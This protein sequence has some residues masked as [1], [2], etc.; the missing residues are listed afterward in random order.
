MTNDKKKII[1]R[2]AFTLYSIIISFGLIILIKYGIANDLRMVLKQGF[3]ASFTYVVVFEVARRFKFSFLNKK[4]FYICLFSIALL[5]GV[6]FFGRKVLGAT[7]SYRWGWFS[8]QPSYFSRLLM[9]EIFAV[10]IAKYHD[11]IVQDKMKEFFKQSSFAVVF[12]IV[13]FGLILIQPHLSVLLITGGSL[14][15]MLFLADL[16]YKHVFT[17]LAIAIVGIFL[18]IGFGSSFRST[19]IIVY[20]KY[21]LLNPY[22]KNVQVSADKERQTKESLIALSSGNFLGTKADFGITSRKLVPEANTDYIFTLIGEEYGFWGAVGILF[23]Y[24]ALFYRLYSKSNR[25]KDPYKRYLALGLSLNLLFTVIVNTGVA[26]AILPSTGVSLPFISYGSSALIMDSL[27][28]A[29]VLNI[30]GKEA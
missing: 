22:R 18:L 19:R 5:I 29:I 3:I 9:I 25:V 14:F 24:A 4:R 7:R 21:A 6:L 20:K 17:I 26:I 1:D 12:I 2:P 13:S 11:L 16:R 10:Y 28:F 27:S 8:F 30:I 15:L 23:L